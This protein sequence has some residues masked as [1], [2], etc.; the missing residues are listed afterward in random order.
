[1]K[2]TILTDNRTNDSQLIAEHGLSV[3]VETARHKLLL[4]T[5]ASDVFIR[6][7][8]RLGIDLTEVDYAFIS[9]GHTDH[10]GGLS[11]FM[12]LNSKAHVLLSPHCLD[13][14]FYS[15]RDGLHPITTDW[16][17]INHSRL[18]LIDKNTQVEDDLWVFP[19]CKNQYPLP[20]GNRHLWAGE[21]A[22]CLVLDDFCH[23]LVLYV[24][25]LLFTGCAHNG[26]ENILATVPTNL[27]LH[28][29]L[30]GFHLLDGYETSEDLLR[31]AQHLKETY[32]KVRFYTS[33]C[34][35]DASLQTMQQ[36]LGEQL[37]GFS[38]GRII[39]A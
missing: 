26:L 15:D 13:R 14:V 9:H 19:S 31:L 28:T 8:E 10:A 22:E 25:G 29:V 1:M 17:S 32:P 12:Q 6:N 16:T 39:E 27:P 5:G 34:T 20:R 7:A 38:V 4:D 23:E 18:K 30:G 11:A 36:V 35:G 2:C 33:H 37:Q 3:Y 24:D 21:T